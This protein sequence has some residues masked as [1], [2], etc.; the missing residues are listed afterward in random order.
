MNGIQL[1]PDNL[2]EVS[3]T[4]SNLD[5]CGKWKQIKRNIFTQIGI[6]QEKENNDDDNVDNDKDGCRM[7]V[8]R[9]LKLEHICTPHQ[10]LRFKDNE[11]NDDDGDRRQW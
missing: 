4:Q 2:N 9:R 6:T 7:V 5:P 1:K 11:N 10:R 8:R 3:L